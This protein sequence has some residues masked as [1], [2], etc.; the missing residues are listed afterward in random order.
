MN[1]SDPLNNAVYDGVKRGI[2][3]CLENEC[4]ASA[5]ILVYS[6]IDTMAFLSMPEGQKDVTRADFVHWCERYLALPG[7]RQITG[8]ELYAARCATVH[9]YGVRSRLSREGKCRMLAYVDH[10]EPPV[11]F[12]EAASKELALVSIK[13]LAQAFLDGVDKFLVDAFSDQASARVVEER[14]QQLLVVSDRKPD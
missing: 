11:L 2:R 5:V 4:F 1:S 8:L 13:H 14:V 3:V 10:S 12:S 9:T 6:G 7:E